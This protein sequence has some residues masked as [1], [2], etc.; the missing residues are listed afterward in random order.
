MTISV[1]NVCVCKC[2]M[3]FPQP[4]NN[5]LFSI[6]C[7]EKLLIIK[8]ED[9]NYTLLMSQFL[10]NWKEIEGSVNVVF[11]TLTFGKDIKIN[12]IKKF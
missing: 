5:E 7:L 9:N 12:F 1:C 6:K 11:A 8:F 3:N 2:F 10:L 4:Y